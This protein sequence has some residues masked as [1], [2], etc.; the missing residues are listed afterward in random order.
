MVLDRDQAKIMEETVT[1]SGGAG[2][3]IRIVQNVID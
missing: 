3:G 1:I 2:G